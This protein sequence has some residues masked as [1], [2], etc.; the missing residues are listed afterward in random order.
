VKRINN[1]LL[2]LFLEFF[3]ALCQNPVTRTGGR[4]RVGVARLQTH[5][6]AVNTISCVGFDPV[7]VAVD[8]GVHAGVASGSAPIAPA[9][10][11]DL[12]GLEVN[13]KSRAREGM[14]RLLLILL[15]HRIKLV[16]LCHIFFRFRSA[17]HFKSTY[18]HG[19]NSI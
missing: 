13:R 10:H 2:C 9:H 6:S 1:N 8:A 12:C 15:A 7:E 16:K 19:F 18:T 17:N 11:A 5:S 4:G 14:L 3:I